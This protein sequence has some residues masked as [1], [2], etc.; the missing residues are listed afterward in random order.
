MYV[1]VLYTIL[2]CYLWKQ[3][4]GGGNYKRSH[5]WHQIKMM[6]NTEDGEGHEFKIKDIIFQNG[7]SSHEKCLL[8]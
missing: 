3:N 1:C 7:A 8:K 4:P 2:S 6:L 5:S